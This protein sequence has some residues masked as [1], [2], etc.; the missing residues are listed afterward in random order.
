[1]VG[2]IRGRPFFRLL[3]KAFGFELSNLGLGLI[4][5][6]LQ[7][8]VPLNGPGVHALPIAHLGSQFGYLLPQLGILTPQLAHLLP[9]LS[10]ES[11]Q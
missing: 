7:F 11:R 10:H 5:F 3:A 6:G 8:D 9:Q 1:M 2:A 4:E